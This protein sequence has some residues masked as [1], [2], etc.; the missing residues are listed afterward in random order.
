MSKKGKDMS[1]EEAVER[2]IADY[3]KALRKYVF[4]Q[5]NAVTPQDALNAFARATLAANVLFCAAALGTKMSDSEIM[6]A[7]EQ[8]AN[9]A[10]DQGKGFVALIEAKG[11]GAMQ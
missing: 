8:I 10:L 6:D 3:R 1:N 4:A 7:L 2:L 9:V 11:W 5:P